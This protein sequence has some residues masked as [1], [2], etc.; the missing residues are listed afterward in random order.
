MSFPASSSGS[1]KKARCVMEFGT[2]WG[3]GEIFNWYR[4]TLTNRIINRLEVRITRDAIPHRFV[5][6]YMQDGSICR[7]DRRPRTPQSVFIPIGPQDLDEEL[8][9][10]AADEACIVNRAELLEIELSTRWEIRLN[11][12]AE[13]DIL[14]VLS[15]CYA[16]AQDKEARTYALREYNCY[17]FAWTIVMLVTRHLL[18]FT[19]PS[20]AAVESRFNSRLAEMS[21]AIADRLVQAMLQVGVNVLAAFD[22]ATGERFNQGLSKQGLAVWGL[23]APVL[24]GVLRQWFKIQ[25]RFCLKG[26]LEQQV[27]SQ[28]EIRTV[29]AIRT[30][31]ETRAAE[32]NQDGAREHDGIADAVENQL[33][34]GQLLADLRQPI[35]DG[36]LD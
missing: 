19:V 8:A 16:I 30:M 27:R 35:H 25:L 22:R 15:A 29:S 24:H 33:W 12:P 13:A 28:L 31:L 6:A 18:P 34:L 1:L 17:F 2:V 3:E 5:V 14:L 23:P 10:R 21:S 20:P 4:D 7:F 26:R 32:G 9:D 36:L 11:L